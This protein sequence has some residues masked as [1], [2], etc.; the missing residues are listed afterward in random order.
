MDECVYYTNRILDKGELT[1]WVFR[2]K[3]PKCNKALMG[4][5]K[6]KK[7]G[8]VKTR[9][10]EYVCPDCGYTLQKQE[11]EDT[12]TVNIGYVC[13][14]C[15]NK[16]DTSEPFKWKKAKIEDQESGK[17]KTLEVIEFKCDKCQNK[18]NLVRKMKA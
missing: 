17:K 3:C 7:T 6:D 5:P 18:L 9:A 4:K 11:Y 13:P 10:T 8:K 1:A 12:L 16:A 15:G 14:H 2:E